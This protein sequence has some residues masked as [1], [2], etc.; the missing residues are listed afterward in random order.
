MTS[1]APNSSPAGL[2]RLEDLPD[3]CTR[4]ELSSL[5]GLSVATLAR[6]AV[7]QRGPR[8]TRLGG[9]AVRYAR[10]DVVSWLSDQRETKSA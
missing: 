4:G 10:E 3:F 7:D 5:T 6:W 9:K 2:R 1:L 8:I